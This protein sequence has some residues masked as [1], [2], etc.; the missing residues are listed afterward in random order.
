MIFSGQ[1]HDRIWK[2]YTSRLSNSDNNKFDSSPFIKKKKLTQ[3]QATPVQTRQ[4]SSVMNS[5]NH[6]KPH[7]R[8]Q[9]FGKDKGPLCFNCHEWGHKGEAC[10]EK[11]IH[12]LAATSD[13]SCYTMA[14]LGERLV[15]AQ[16]NSGT[17]ISLTGVHLFRHLHLTHQRSQSPVFGV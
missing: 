11:Q 16:I 13:S 4:E 14:R 12:R 8:A 6:T 2:R 10:P 15:H 3:K 5:G 7:R 17:I 9:Y 1:V